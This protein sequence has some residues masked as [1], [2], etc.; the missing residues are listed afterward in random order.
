[1]RED[2]RKIVVAGVVRPVAFAAGFAG[3]LV[4]ALVSLP[5]WAPALTSDG[6]EQGAT[7]G[8]APGSVPALVQRHDCWTGAAPAEQAGRV[9]GHVVV[10][11][12]GGDPQLSATLVDAALAHVFE[13]PRRGL[14]VHAFCR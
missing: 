8:A 13:V 2:R 12:R 6:E 1:M 14:T 11:V 10:T 5:L 3:V 4:G 7:S 9:P